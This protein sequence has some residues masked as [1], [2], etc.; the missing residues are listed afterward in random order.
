MSDSQRIL[1]LL[2][3][4][5]QILSIAWRMKCHFGIIWMNYGE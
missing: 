1:S 5:N 4:Y 2:V 3:Q